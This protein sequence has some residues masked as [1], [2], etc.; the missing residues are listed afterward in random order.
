MCGAA[1]EGIV[2]HFKINKTLFD[3]LNELRKR[4]IIDKRLHEWGDEIRKLRN[5]AAH[6]PKGKVE[7]DD[8]ASLMEFTEAICDYV[9]VLAER[10]DAFRMRQ[11]TKAAK[12]RK[13][14]KPPLAPAA[15]PAAVV[16]IAEPP[17]TSASSAPV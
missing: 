2:H 14:R 1:L 12:N 11:K 4:D 5:I 8:A 9:F 6:D 15:S 10:F 17:A 16:P 7:P 13:K 3:G